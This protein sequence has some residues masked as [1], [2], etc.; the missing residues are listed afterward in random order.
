MRLFEVA[1]LDLGSVDSFLRILK[2][3]ANKSDDYRTI[4]FLAL[5]TAIGKTFGIPIG[6]GGPAS[7]QALEQFFD[8]VPSIKNVIDNIDPKTAQITVKT[9]TENPN[10]PADLEIPGKS[11]TVD[12]M[13]HAVTSREYGV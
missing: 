4:P 13:A 12:T 5:K 2:D 7:A 3:L 9:D 6:D 8:K 1:D 11:P 10:K